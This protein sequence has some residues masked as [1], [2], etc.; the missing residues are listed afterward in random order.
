MN[1]IKL[2]NQ[3]F[4]YGVKRAI[5]ICLD[6]KED[7]TLPR[8][9]YL[10]GNIVHNDHIF[11]VLKEIGIIVVE[12]DN[13][14]KMLDEIPNNVTVI[15]SAHGVSDKV[16][17]K[18]KSKNLTII[19]A[20]CPYVEK[21]F[22]LVSDACGKGYDVLYIGKNNH[23]ETEAIL[24]LSSKAHLVDPFNIGKDK[25][26]NK[27]ITVAHQTT[28]SCYDIDSL[29]KKIKETYP[30]VE[31]LDMI[32]RVTEQRQTELRQIVNENDN[33]ETLAIIIGDKKSNNSTK[34]YE[35][36]TRGEKLSS[37]FIE[38]IQELDLEF[39]NKFK[40]IIIASGT[41]T[42]QAIIDEVCNTLSNITTTKERFIKSEVT[43][44]DL[45]H[46]I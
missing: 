36:A 8:P 42:P 37:V 18:A 21:T 29:Y 40:V 27:Y 15:F 22:K 11:Q 5:Q 46:S 19:D 12:G 2:K 33:E 10:L 34:L 41:S 6:A 13:R 39:A 31:R 7:S 32:C 44:Q 24:E 20:T 30:T 28:M 38:S 35:L 17:Q 45:I 1:I 14:L 4:C 23:P 3:G 16:V 26:S 43:T 9:I 25:L